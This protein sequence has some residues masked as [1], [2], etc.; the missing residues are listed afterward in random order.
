MK[1]T[2]DSRAAKPPS[3]VA[4]RQR[5]RPV[6]PPVP[7][8]VVVPVV[9]I[10][11][12][13]GGLEA[14]EAFFGGV[15]ADSGL[16]FVVV[17]HLDPTHDTILAELLQRRTTMPVAEATDNTTVEPDHVYVIPPNREMTLSGGGVLHLA[18]PPSARGHRLPIDVFLRTLA[19]D[20]ADSGVA[21]ILSGMG[22]DGTLGVKA[23]K[24]AGGLVLAQTPADAKFDSMPRSAIDTGVV[25]IVAAAADLC[26]RILGLRHNTVVGPTRETEGSERGPHGLEKVLVLLRART[27]QD[28]SHYKKTTLSRRVERRMGVHQIPKL[29]LYVQFLQENPQE[30]DLL[31]KEL[32]IGVT[33]FFRDPPCWEYLLRH[34]L[35]ELYDRHPERGTVRAWTA[36]CSTGEE[37]YSLGIVL[38]EAL[39]QERPGKSLGFQIFATD[40]DPDAITRAR[41]GIYPANIAVDVSSERLTRFF[42]V[43]DS[44]SG[45]D[46]APRR[47]R[48]GREVREMVTL[49]TQNVVTD[50][51]FTRL[52]LIVCRNL[53]I[54]LEPEAQKRLIGVFHYCLNPGGILFLGNAEAIGSHTDRFEP[55][56]GKFRIFRRLESAQRFALPELASSSAGRVPHQLSGQA[57]APPNLQGL[58][59]HILLQRYA[60]AAV[61]I[62]AEGDILYISGRTGK[63]LEPAAGK[64]NFN[65]FAMAREGLSGALTTALH[66]AGS[67]PEVVTVADLQVRT[68]GSFQPIN[69]TVQ[70]LHDPPE[71]RGTFFV[72]FA[73]QPPTKTSRVRDR[74]QMAVVAGADER[75]S[76]LRRLRTELRTERE[77]MQS[78]REE[79]RSTNE[80]LQSTNEELQSANEELTTSKEEMQSLNEELQTVNGELRAKVDQLMQTGSDLKNLLNSTEIAV[81]FL[82]SALNV[83]RFTPRITRIFKLIPQDEGRP[84]TDIVTELFYPS[85]NEDVVEVLRTLLPIE[86]QVTTLDGRWFSARIMPYR[87]LDNVIDGVVVTFADITAAKTLE[88]E[89]RRSGHEGELL[90]TLGVAP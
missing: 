86:N 17:Q 25:D 61:L 67:T 15:P 49:A 52:D 69:L 9:G 16:G 36:G 26:G 45:P 22:T 28:F 42:V 82:D 85:L 64:A 23:V 79:L 70:A 12:S 21:V 5:R 84:I 6:T 44:S 31:F 34:A 90:G 7:P 10:G 19:A 32:L 50:P 37:A 14:L 89:L 41:Q 54:Y 51:P 58:A 72:I 2:G 24:E 35:P 38:R 74:K 47:Y 11:A 8:P 76:E 1:T 81:L 20:Q 75:D 53:L 60:P 66:Q 33:N 46:V 13:A 56:D 65:I 83:R 43:E 68:N 39:E 71:L 3:S 30:L 62:N 48:I 18:V 77:E 63:Y 73:D 40:L 88:A 4:S 59:D 78:W 29:A 80:E 55:V 87:T 27:H 57:P